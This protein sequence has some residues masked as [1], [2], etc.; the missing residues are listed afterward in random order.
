MHGKPKRVRKIWNFRYQPQF[1]WVPCLWFGRAYAS[2]LFGRGLCFCNRI[3]TAI[4]SLHKNQCIHNMRVT[5]GHQHKMLSIQT[6]LQLYC[7]HGTRLPDRHFVPARSAA[8]DRVR[9][10]ATSRPHEGLY[11]EALSQTTQTRTKKTQVDER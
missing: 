9:R 6:L 8:N 5:R 3:Y 2:E 1:K 10:P 7:T 11:A 4:C